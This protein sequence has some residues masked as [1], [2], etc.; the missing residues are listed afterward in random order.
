MFVH[1]PSRICTH[2]SLMPIETFAL[3]F[4][5]GKSRGCEKPAVVGVAPG[6]AFWFRAKKVGALPKRMAIPADAVTSISA[7]KALVIKRSQ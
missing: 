5:G 2:P 7:K 6:T 4:T 3:I 1:G